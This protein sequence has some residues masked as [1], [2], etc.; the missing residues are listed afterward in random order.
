MVTCVVFTTRLVA[1]CT[2]NAGDAENVRRRDVE[3]FDY[4]S[5]IVCVDHRDLT[6]VVLSRTNPQ[7]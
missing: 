2:W 5:G 3:G 7:Q 1:A 6:V 4:L